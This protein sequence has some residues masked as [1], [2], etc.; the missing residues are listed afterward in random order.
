MILQDAAT[1]GDLMWSPDPRNGSYCNVYSLRGFEHVEIPYEEVWQIGG[2]TPGDNFPGLR[3]LSAAQGDAL[4]AG[5]RI[6]TT[7]AAEQEAA[8]ERALAAALERR[9]RDRRGEKQLWS[10]VCQAGAQLV[11]GLLTLQPAVRYPA[12]RPVPGPAGC[13]KHPVPARL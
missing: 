9:Q 1:F 3:L 11:A 7:T 8:A 5:L 10:S 12:Y 13:G 2:F 6:A 4:L